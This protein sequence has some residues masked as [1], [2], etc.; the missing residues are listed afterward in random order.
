MPLTNGSQPMKPVRGSALRLRDQ[1]L[2]AAEADF[3]TDVVDGDGNSA[4][5]IRRRLR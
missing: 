2:G 5:E 1:M 3:E 4:R